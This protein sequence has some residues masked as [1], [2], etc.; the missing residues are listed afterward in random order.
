MVFKANLKSL[1]KFVSFFHPLQNALFPLSAW[2]W[3]DLDESSRPK[4][5]CAWE[6]ESHPEGVCIAG[7]QRSR[8]FSRSQDSKGARIQKT[9]ERQDALDVVLQCP[10]LQ[11]VFPGA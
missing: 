2:K 11:L 10:S 1:E 4:E 8:G 5:G 7:G 6:R 9:D 3:E